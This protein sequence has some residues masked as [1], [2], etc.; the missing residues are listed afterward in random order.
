VIARH[1]IVVHPRVELRFRLLMEEHGYAVPIRP[2]PSSTYPT[3]AF[4][5]EAPVE[6]KWDFL[7]PDILPPRMCW[8]QP[9][10]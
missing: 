8:P 2:H 10:A 6:E 4:I 5:V 9:E 3:L 1:R 7:R